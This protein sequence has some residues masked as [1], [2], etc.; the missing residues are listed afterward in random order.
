MYKV[1]CNVGPD[2]Q[3]AVPQI[4]SNKIVITWEPAI[5]ASRINV[6]KL[7]AM[8][9][10]NV[11]LIPKRSDINPPNLAPPKLLDQNLKELDSMLYYS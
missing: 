10:N 5:V 8:P 4:K 11:E 2:V 6:R 9:I 1:I 3:A 7:I